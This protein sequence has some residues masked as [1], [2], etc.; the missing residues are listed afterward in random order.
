MWNKNSNSAV[1]G[2][3]SLLTAWLLVAAPCVFASETPHEVVEEVTVQMVDVIVEHQPTFK[4]DPDSFYSALDSL[5]NDAV[6]FDWIAYNVMGPYRKQ[7]TADQRKRFSVKFRR[8]LIKTYGGGLI[9]FGDQKIVVLP[10]AEDVEGKR[11]VRVDQEIHGA[12]GVFP[13]H[14]TMGLNRQGEWK[15]TNVI[16]NGVNLGKT[17]RNQFLQRAQ[18]YNGDIDQVIDNWSSSGSL[19]TASDSL[20]A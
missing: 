18:K 15:V 2:F 5:L 14:Y 3:F 9:S 4:E 11:T 12:E 8:D 7:A 19:D 16:I 6:D 20:D 13:L 17:F 10:P 1:K